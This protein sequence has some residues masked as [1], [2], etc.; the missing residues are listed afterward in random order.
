MEGTKELITTD[1]IRSNVYII[2]G[3][4]RKSVV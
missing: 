3:Q 1:D 2:R 4:D